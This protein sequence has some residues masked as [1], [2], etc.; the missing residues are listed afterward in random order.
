MVGVNGTSEIISWDIDHRCKS[1]NLWWLLPKLSNLGVAPSAFTPETK[2]ATR[3]PTPT[4]RQRLT[5]RKQKLNR[6]NL[7]FRRL[8]FLEMSS[9]AVWPC[10]QGKSSENFQLKVM[11]PPVK[12]AG[13]DAKFWCVDSM[14][15][16]VGR[17]ISYWFR[18]GLRTV[19]YGF[20]CLLTC[21]YLKV[22]FGLLAWS[23]NGQ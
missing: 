19:S 1:H 4:I 15:L 8:G 18:M 21:P 10:Q 11:C 7:W 14:C 6:R 17:I 13:P 12:T 23:P 20:R 9:K 5:K 2:L 3:R 16:Q 22:N